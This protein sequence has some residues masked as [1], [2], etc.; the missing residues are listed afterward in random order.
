ML[1][2]LFHHNSHVLGGKLTI[3]NIRKRVDPD[4]FAFTKRN[5]PG[6][7]PLILGNLKLY[8]YNSYVGH[9]VSWY[10]C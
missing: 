2:V 9:K 8:T 6:M 1:I 4:S 10:D 5:D 3:S 7:C